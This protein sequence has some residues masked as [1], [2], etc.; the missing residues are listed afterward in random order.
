VR[1]CKVARFDSEYRHFGFI[2]D[3]GGIGSH[4]DTDYTTLVRFVE[5]P[6]MWKD[7]LHVEPHQ[8]RFDEIDKKR[9]VVLVVFDFDEALTLATFM[10]K[11]PECATQIG[12]SPSD[13]SGEWSKSD[14]VSYNF[15]SP[16]VEWSR[17]EELK[18]LLKSLQAPASGSRKL[19]VLSRNTCGVVAI[20]NLLT[21]A[22]LAEHFSAIWTMEKSDDIPSGVYQEEGVWKPF[23]TPVKEVYKHKADILCH[24]AENPL[25]WFPQFSSTKAFSSE[26]RP[27]LKPEGIVL[28]DDERFNFRSDAE[29]HAKVLRYVKVPRYDDDYRDCGAMHQLGGVGAH[30]VTDFATVLSFVEAPW[31][32]PTTE[33]LNLAH[34]ASGLSER[35]TGSEVDQISQRDRS[36][37]ET[38]MLEDKPSRETTE[39]EIKVSS[40][41]ELCSSI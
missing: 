19:A 15:E 3:M 13:A 28:I 4:S 21:L 34:S 16:Y 35:R 32:Y 29:S 1:F 33:A 36:L 39:D 17:V 30:E 27:Q 26:A 10:P 23:D 37:S 11:D 41:R 20:L 2:K 38:I 24:V 22:G 6:W 31:E 12:W 8:W 5:R 9:P 18:K 7:T 40:P 14:L 25:R